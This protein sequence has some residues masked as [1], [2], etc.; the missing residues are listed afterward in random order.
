MDLKKMAGE[1]PEIPGVYIMKDSYENIIYVGKAKK[2]KN[3][4]SQYFRGSDRHS[5]KIIR[6][7]ENISTFEY[8]TV[9]TELE[10]LLLE[11]RLIKDLKPVYNSQMKNDR[12]YVYIRISE[13]EFPALEIM[14]ERADSGICFGPYTSEKSVERAL[15]ALQDNFK[16]RHCSS[17]TARKSGCLRQQLGLCLAPCTGE[18]DKKEYLE[19]IDEAIGFLE[20]RSL[21]LLTHLQR[22]MEAAADSLDFNKAVRYRDD[23]KALKRLVSRQRAVGF[24]QQNK[25]LA[26]IEKLDDSIA[27]FFI[28]KGSHITYKTKLEIGGLD[29]AALKCQVKDLIIRHI[30]DYSI[31]TS[32]LDKREVDQA[33]I[34]YS[35]LKNKKGCCYINIPA[36]WLKGND[37]S[38]LERGVDKLVGKLYK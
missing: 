32:G 36:A 16:L 12:G 26:V 15:M 17:F 33:H 8:I 21:E 35:Y 31:G 22:K 38:K 6:M 2:L 11:C 30:K 20:G 3:R 18:V 37:Y 24:T 13:E 28:M 25:S 29:N 19:Q 9:D 27:K 7:I 34:V 5:P 14:E 10:A 23:L 4:V 1:L